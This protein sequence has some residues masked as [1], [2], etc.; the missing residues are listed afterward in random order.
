MGSSKNQV[1]ANLQFLNL[2]ESKNFLTWWYVDRA[3]PRCGLGPTSALSF[4][5]K[6]RGQPP[7]WQPLRDTLPPPPSARPASAGVGTPSAPSR[8]P[9]LPRPGCRRDRRPQQDGLVLYQRFSAR[10]GDTGGCPPRS[11]KF[12]RSEAA[13]RAAAG[14]PPAMPSPPAPRTAPW[15][16]PRFTPG[17]E[18]E[19]HDLKPSGIPVPAHHLPGP[20]AGSRG[21][22]ADRP[23]AAAGPAAGPCSGSGRGAARPLPSSFS[24]PR[25]RRAA[26]AAVPARK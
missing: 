23:A 15:P 12:S 1:F 5:T 21:G 7:A 25:R 2:T 10:K 26:A 17:L 22:S 4:P 14:R 18:G 9:R 20:A 16:A 19:G 3:K 11:A 24:L 6:R 13:R 8:R